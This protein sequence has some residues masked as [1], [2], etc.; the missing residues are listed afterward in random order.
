MGM[1]EPVDIV[2]EQDRVVSTSTK[3]E[4]HTKGFLHRCV[5]AQVNDSKGRWLFVKQASDRQDA[6]QYVCP[7]GGHVQAGETADDALKR[8]AFEELGITKFHFKF[9][10]KLIF[11]R[12]VVG[13]QENHYFL[14]YEVIC[15]E[16]PRIN[17]ESESF[18]YFTKA[19]LKELL[20]K[21]PD[22]FGHAYHVL[23]KE[24]YEDLLS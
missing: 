13:R 15:D 11:N 20:A 4:A 24:F 2:D 23:V 6:G 9:I 19:E 21:N 5:I 14:H 17:H 10:G 18:I 12:F 8:E 22:A 1:D 3:K 7:V 16:T